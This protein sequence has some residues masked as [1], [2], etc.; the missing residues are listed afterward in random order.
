MTG[1]G[2]EQIKDAIG[3][4]EGGSRGWQYDVAT[5]RAGPFLGRKETAREE[6]LERGS[7]KRRIV[8]K[9]RMEEERMP[10]PKPWRPEG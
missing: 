4:R 2:R 5:E 3:E 8:E 6:R 7:D 10:M 1:G 9:G